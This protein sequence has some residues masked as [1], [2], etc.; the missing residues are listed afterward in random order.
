M[1]VSLLLACA[2][3]PEDTAAATD[4]QEPICGSAE[5]IGYVAPTLPNVMLAVDRSRSMADDGKWQSLLAMTPYLEAVEASSNLGLTLY[6]AESDCDATIAVPVSSDD[7]A[8][9]AIADAL[10]S[11]S[12]GGGTPI[13]AALRLIRQEGGMQDAD[14]DNVVVLVTDGMPSCLG[15]AVE[16]AEALA[17][18]EVPIKLHVLGLGNGADQNQLS[19]LAEAAEPSTGPD[20]LYMA[21][22]VEDLLG[23]LDHIAAALSPCTYALE[24]TVVA[25]TL[26]VTVAGERL[27]ECEEADC[28]EGYA[29]DQD[30]ASVTL[31]AVSCRAALE[32]GCPDVVFDGEVL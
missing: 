16:E 28:V 13:A 9:L 4:T 31:A 18:A 6:P 12:P 30:A 29:Y 1:F 20:N 10:S 22:D 14:R 15:D 25:D 8:D 23:R 7:D 5:G 19:E 11:S 3:S 2:P 24:E 26:Q 17:T 21:E 27:S 32:N